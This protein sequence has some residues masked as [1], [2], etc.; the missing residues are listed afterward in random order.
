[1]SPSSAGRPGRAGGPGPKLGPGLSRALLARFPGGV[2][3]LDAETTGLSPFSDRIV[4]LAGARL[5]PDGS[6]G[7]F[8]SLADPGVPVPARAAAVHG[9]T[10]AMVAG[11]PPEGEVV[12]R[13]FRFARGAPLVAH[14]ARF[15][16]GFL[17]GALLRAGAPRHSHILL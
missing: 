12:S 10:D 13:F 9:V 17:A 3:A 8:D 16:A 2:A 11:A 14:N 7:V 5:L 1:M 4:E 15:D 6:V